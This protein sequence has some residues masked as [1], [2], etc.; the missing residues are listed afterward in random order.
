[1]L[2][3]DQGLN[4]PEILRGN[5]EPPSNSGITVE[6][7]TIDVNGNYVLDNNKNIFI[8]YGV[9]AFM[10]KYETVD[11][12]LR[13]RL[14]DFGSDLTDGESV[15]NKYGM[16]PE[17][18]TQEY[19]DT[20]YTITDRQSCNDLNFNRNLRTY[21]TTKQVI[22]PCRDHNQYCETWVSE[23]LCEVSKYMQENCKRSCNLCPEQ[24][25]IDIL[26]PD[27]THVM[28]R[29]HDKEMNMEWRDLRYLD[30]NNY[31]NFSFGNTEENDSFGG[32][33]LIN[34]DGANRVERCKYNP[35]EPKYIEET[36]SVDNSED[37]IE[38]CKENAMH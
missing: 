38:E 19:I 21:D 36:Y 12:E 33:S 31:D 6:P 3:I 29:Q 35:N 15:C 23:D 27:V 2:M 4:I 18:S 16:S 1:M 22:A 26:P 13:S 9:S 8:D 10:Y 28:K 5:M 34:I 17:T 30:I 7:L 14:P 37:L 32:S 24:E 25:V 11:S 20:D